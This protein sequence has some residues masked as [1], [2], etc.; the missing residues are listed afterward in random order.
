VQVICTSRYSVTKEVVLKME[1]ELGETFAKLFVK[2]EHKSLRPNVEGLV[3][4]ILKDLGVPEE[5]I[6]PTMAVLFATD[7]TVA[8]HPNYEVEHKRLPEKTRMILDQA[9]VRQQ[10]G[11]KFLDH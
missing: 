11:L 9:V 4:Q 7:V 10:P 6:E 5:R 2:G 8:A 3:K 1:K